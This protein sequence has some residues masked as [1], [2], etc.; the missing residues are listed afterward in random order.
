MNKRIDKS[1][2]KLNIYTNQVILSTKEAQQFYTIHQ[3]S[4]IDPQ[5]TM[6][7]GEHRPVPKERFRKISGVVLEPFSVRIIMIF[8]NNN[9]NNAFGI[10]F[11]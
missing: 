11:N 3:K 1:I 6:I 8:N 7:Q 4:D 5:S 2:Q 10:R 9:N